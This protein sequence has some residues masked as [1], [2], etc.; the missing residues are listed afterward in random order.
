MS[1]SPFFL[2]ESKNPLNLK[3]LY[4]SSDIL[5][6]PYARYAF[7][8]ALKQH[9]IKSIYLPSFICRDMLS[10]INALNIDY[11]FYDVN[12]KLE[13]LLEETQC[14]AIVI[15][16]YFGFEQTM[17]PFLD[18]QKK[19]GALIIED[20]AHGLF[21][22]DRIGNFL[23]TRGD[24][25]LLSIRKTISLPNGA[26][27]LVNN[28]SFKNIPYTSAP[29]QKTHEDNRYFSKQ[30]LKEKIVHQ[31]IGIAIVLLRRVLRF[32]KTGSV[33]P[34][35]D[36]MSEQELPEN[37]Y[38]TPL[39]VEGN[40]PI[41]I[42]EEVKRRLQMYRSIEEWAKRFGIKPIYP[43]YE[44]VSPYEFAFIDNGKADQFE[45]FLFF[46]GF[47][48]LPWPDLPKEIVSTCPEF[49]KNIKVVP[50]LW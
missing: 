37:S 36:P 49:Y 48:I 31:S 1:L 12:E 41:D 4:S 32:I 10:P 6:Y 5:L 45:K 7:L 11:V 47:F 29:I 40:V 27:L 22:K 9:T 44:G 50:F 33:L 16:N 43:L 38:L 18:Y 30:R 39:L 23:G 35:P 8:E 21:S 25:G 42:N 13:P 34:F 28:E 46:K 2:Q 19:Y 15:V 24:F 17:V 26:A 20:N 3:Q 14:D